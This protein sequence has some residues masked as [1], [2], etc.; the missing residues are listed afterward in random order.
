MSQTYPATVSDFRL[1]RYEIT[2]GP[3]PT[4]W[5]CTPEHHP[6][7]RRARIR[8]PP[9]RAGTPPGTPSWRW[10]RRR[11]RPRSSATPSIG[12]WTDAPV[13][14]RMSVAL[15]CSTGT[16][17]SRSASGT[18]AGCRRRR[19][20]TTR[21]P[22]G[23]EQ[24]AVSVVDPSDQRPPSTTTYAI[25]ASTRSRCIAPSSARSPKGDG[26]WGHA[27]M[28]GNVWEWVQDGWTICA[29]VRAP[30][31][32]SSGSPR[33][34]G[35][36]AAPTAPRPTFSPHSAPMR[37][38][39]TTALSRE[40]AAPQRAL[41]PAAI[42]NHGP[43]SWN[44]AYD[45]SR[46]P[47][48]HRASSRDGD[49]AKDCRV[50]CEDADN[51]CVQKCTRTMRARPCSPPTW[52]TAGLLANRSRPRRPTLTAGSRARGAG[53]SRASPGSARSPRPGSCSRRRRRSSR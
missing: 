26:K 27:D 21:R 2:R 11:S 6:V 15:S 32:P 4:S 39:W 20:G 5:R 50:K 23:S 45:G 38:R 3:L 29:I 19:S 16:R 13:H 31:A 52:T 7:G 37:P 22:A 1:D 42:G 48:G 17:H 41:I 10:T 47:S 33:S 24:R 49:A 28:A 9:T 53:L 8:R 14:R 40:R 46:A 34:H 30:T 35:Q 18:A 25:H 44:S 36:A 43:L 51:V 12:T